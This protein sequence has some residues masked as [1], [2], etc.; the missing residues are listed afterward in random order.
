MGNTQNTSALKILLNETSHSSLLSIPCIDA[1][2]KVWC[3]SIIQPPKAWWFLEL[4][5]FAWVAQ[6]HLSQLD[7]RN[8][9]SFQVVTRHENSELSCA[10]AQMW[11]G[12]LVVFIGGSIRIPNRRTPKHQ[13]IMIKASLWW[14]AT[15]LP[16]SGLFLAYPWN[17]AKGP[18]P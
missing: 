11:N 6:I 18:R 10:K 16:R 3:F 15:H 14:H 4:S 7:Y 8:L 13:T 9:S 12:W 2:S 17:N 1:P 5:F